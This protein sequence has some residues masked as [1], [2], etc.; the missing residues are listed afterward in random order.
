MTKQKSI[1]L[2][3]ELHRR[4]KVAAAERGV[5]IRAFVER[6]VK[7]K[8]ERKTEHENQTRSTAP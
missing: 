4:L 3:Q 8:I 1:N 6:A 7:E 5:S 2:P